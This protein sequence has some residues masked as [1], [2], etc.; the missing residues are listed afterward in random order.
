MI[1][2]GVV[3]LVL[4]YLLGVPFL[5]TLGIIAIIVGAVFWSS[6]RPA[7][8][9]RA[10][11]TG[12]DPSLRPRSARLEF[13]DWSRRGTNIGSAAGPQWSSC[14]RQSQR[15]ALTHSLNAAK[16]PASPDRRKRPPSCPWPTQTLH[17]NGH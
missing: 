15:T 16:S 11:G 10:A 2:L 3:L 7:V 6:V 13:P 5:W 12:I 9:S 8:R 17:A 4:G 14:C 1:V